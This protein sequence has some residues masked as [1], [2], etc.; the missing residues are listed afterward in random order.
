MLHSHNQ[1]GT[2]LEKINVRG[3]VDGPV[4]PSNKKTRIEL[5]CVF[6]QALSTFTFL[7]LLT[8]RINDKL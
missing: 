7:S 5:N 2:C 8:Y 1:I 4:N 3:P 6:S